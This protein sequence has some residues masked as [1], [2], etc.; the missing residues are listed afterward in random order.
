MDYVVGF[1]FSADGQKVL[2]IRK[3][4]PEWQA[5]KLNGIGGKIETTDKDKWT[6]M[7]REFVEEAGIETDPYDWMHVITF[8]H[9][10]NGANIYIFYYA[11]SAD[12]DTAKQLTSEE[13]VSIWYPIAQVDQKQLIHNCRWT[14]PYIHEYYVQGSGGKGS[15]K[16]NPQRPLVVTFHHD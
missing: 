15:V 6:A 13:L 10:Q 5:G 2:L 4:K 11:G 1:M 7:A 16:G 3:N 9:A 12:I 14:L 8:T